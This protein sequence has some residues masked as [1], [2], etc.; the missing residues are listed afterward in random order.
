MKGLIRSSFLFIIGLIVLSG[1]SN[2]GG[3]DVGIAM[4]QTDYERWK[5]DAAAMEESLTE[6]GYNVETQFANSDQTEQNKQISNMVTNGAQVI[7]VASVNEGAAT[8]VEEAQRDGVQVIAYDRL[9]TGTDAYDYYVTFDN[10]K[11]GVLQAQSI[12]DKFDLDNASE[13]INMTLFA[14][15]PTDNNSKFFFDGAMSVLQPYI[16]EGKINVCGPAPT[17]SEDAA[18][19]KITTE[20]WASDTAKKRMETLLAA[21]CKDAQLDAVLAPADG[22]SRAVIGALE[23]EDKYKDS[24]PYVTGQDAE[25][26]SVNWILNGKQG[27]TIWKDTRDLAQAAAEVADALIRGEEPSLTVEATKDNE[28][29]DTGKK[30]VTTYTLQPEVIDATNAESELVDSG[31]YTLEDITGASSEATE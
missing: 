29:Y 21:D 26:L 15:S 13:P 1:C 9:I 3:L 10:F 19:S 31:Y 20:N 16:D 5:N 18:F 23:V 12:I 22:I 7:I 2:G 11:V 25:K 27:M 28:T 24:L 4:P 8:A 6:M 17:S 14:G 30:I